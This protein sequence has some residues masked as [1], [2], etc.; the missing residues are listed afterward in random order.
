MP[1]VG[2]TGVAYLALT[3]GRPWA[4]VVAAFTFLSYVGIYTPL[5]A[6]TSLNTLIGAVPGALPPV[7][8]WCAVRGDLDFEAGALFLITLL[9]NI[10]AQRVLKRYRQ[11][12][13]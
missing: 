3:L 10:T 7:I 4:A 6:R 12:Y 11:V 5:K 8:G 9:M 1:S 2:V 13:Q